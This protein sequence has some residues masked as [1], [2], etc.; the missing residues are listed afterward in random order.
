MFSNDM[1]KLSSY[2]IYYEIYNTLC[3]VALLSL[4]IVLQYLGSGNL[5]SLG[6]QSQVGK[7]TKTQSEP[8]TRSDALVC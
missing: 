8:T 4:I 2:K 7:F 6:S 3:N 1:E 5:G